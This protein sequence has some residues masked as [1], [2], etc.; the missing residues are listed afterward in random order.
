MGSEPATPNSRRAASNTGAINPAGRPTRRRV[1][2]SVKNPEA[3][4][5]SPFGQEGQPS[6]EWPATQLA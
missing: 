1:L 5:G 6:Q 4:L 2:Y 3:N